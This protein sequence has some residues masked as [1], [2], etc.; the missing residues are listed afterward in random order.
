MHGKMYAVLTQMITMQLVRT[1]P[2]NSFYHYVW[3]MDTGEAKEI[4][5]VKKFSKDRSLLLGS[6]PITEQ[7]ETLLKNF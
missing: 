1:S 3:L 5:V 7:V 4:Q 2:A 6:I